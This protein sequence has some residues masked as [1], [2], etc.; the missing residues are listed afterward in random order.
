ML[1][2]EPIVAITNAAHDSMALRMAVC[3]DCEELCATFLQQ[4][5]MQAL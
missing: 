4:E 1:A 3:I 5:S 2:L